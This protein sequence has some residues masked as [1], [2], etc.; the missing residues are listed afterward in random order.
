MEEVASHRFTWAAVIVAII[1]VVPGLF[2]GGIVANIYKWFLS[3]YFGQDSWLGFFN[4]INKVAMLW[5]PSL[6]HGC[7][8]GVVALYITRNLFKVA[9]LEI[10]SYAASA[11]WIVSGMTLGAFGA[12]VAGVEEGLVGLGAQIVGVA[13][14]LF[15]FKFEKG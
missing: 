11:V 6:L 3:G 4:F 12:A 15:S 7:I 10:V 9:N 2:V 13:V 1:M 14:G 8:A 5:F